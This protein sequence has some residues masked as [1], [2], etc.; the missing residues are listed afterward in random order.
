MLT[1]KKVSPAIGAEV[2]GVDF[3]STVTPEL[4]EAIYELLLENLVLF[5]PGSAEKS[6]SG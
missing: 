6:S 4:N 5:F 3:T 2:K 1:V